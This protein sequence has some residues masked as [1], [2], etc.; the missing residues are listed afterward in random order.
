MKKV[1]FNP[2][3]RSTTI[4][5]ID[6]IVA[7]KYNKNLDADKGKYIRSFYIKIALIMVLF[8]ILIIILS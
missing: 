8:S 5:H 1:R 7:S 4:D 6:R 2:K 3:I